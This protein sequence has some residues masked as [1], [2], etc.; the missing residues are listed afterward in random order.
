MRL[1]LL[2]YNIQTGISTRAYHEYLTK[3]WRHVLPS[4]RRQANLDRIA[5]VVAAYDV[6]GLQE[7]DGGSLR[8]GYINQVEY[9]ALR[10]GFPWWHSQI[11][12]NLGRL[13]QHAN[14]LLSRLRPTEI[15][16]HRLP[17]RIPGRGALFVRYGDDPPLVLLILHLALGARAR[18]AQL[19]YVAELAGRYPHVVLMGD[20]NCRASPLDETDAFAGTGLQE[21]PGLG[22]TFPSWAPRR[23]IDRL[24]VSPSL[25]VHRLEVLPCTCS[26]HLPVAAE[27]DL[28]PDLAASVAACRVDLAAT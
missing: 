18:R 27:I 17:G 1:R 28:P 14:G 7:V 8:S 4:A 9:L 16:E 19:A 15:R 26:D 13:A 23:C 6:V 25:R 11:N 2:S 10:A 21:P 20:M 5:Q 22:P 12:R 24:L 3:G